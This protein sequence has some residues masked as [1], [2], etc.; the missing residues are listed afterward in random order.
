LEDA[1]EQ[2]QQFL[3]TGAAQGAALVG[4][5]AE[6]A[7]LEDVNV[8]AVREMD[9]PFAARLSERVGLEIRVLDFASFQAGD[10][11]FAVL[12]SDALAVSA[13]VSD[14]IRSLGLFAASLPV[15]ASSGETVAL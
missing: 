15:S 4:A 10:G 3:V 9:G 14:R 1:E 5:K 7:S 12:N 11:D 6:V 2:G 13:P 8:M